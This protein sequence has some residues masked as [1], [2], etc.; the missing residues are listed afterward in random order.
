[1]NKTRKSWKTKKKKKKKKKKNKNEEEEEEEKDD[2]E[3]E[4]EQERRGRRISIAP[5]FTPWR[6]SRWPHQPSPPIL[7]ANIN[8]ILS[9]SS[10]Q[11]ALIKNIKHSNCPLFAALGP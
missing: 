7:G 5:C 4:E 1:M 8:A 11:H 9:L 10:F 3:Q 6:Y 2:E